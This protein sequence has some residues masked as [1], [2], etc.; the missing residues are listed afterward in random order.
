MSKLNTKML[1]LS[2]AAAAAVGAISIPT[3]ASA[4][5]YDRRHN[6][7]TTGAVVGA[8]AGAAIG[9]TVAG[10]RDRT[11]GTVLGAVVGAA[12]GSSVARNNS[13][14]DYDGGYYGR[15]GD[16]VVYDY[17][18][19]GDHRDRRDDRRDYRDDRRYDRRD[20]HR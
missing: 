4:D 8:V 5:C 17:R 2:V 3:L 1:I 19:R 14:C 20:D 16:T 15:G 7:G 12:V 10:R 6:A 11:A 18:G 13:R 9:N